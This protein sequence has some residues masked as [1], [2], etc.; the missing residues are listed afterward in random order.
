MRTRF[1]N[2]QA[3]FYV[4]CIVGVLVLCGIILWDYYSGIYVPGSAGTTCR[5]WLTECAKYRPLA[6]CRSDVVQLGCAAP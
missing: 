5:S 6:D 1:I 2:G 3:M 4:G